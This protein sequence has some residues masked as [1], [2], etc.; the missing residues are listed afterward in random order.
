[1]L[2]INLKRKFGKSIQKLKQV[3]ESNNFSVQ[4]LIKPFKSWIFKV[5]VK[6]KIRGMF[7]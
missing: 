7:S 2:F 4:S 6:F 1:M 5:R 3:S